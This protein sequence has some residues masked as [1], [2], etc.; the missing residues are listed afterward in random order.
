MKKKTKQSRKKDRWLAVGAL[1]AST[2]F[3]SRMTTPAFAK[4][5]LERTNPSLT[6]DFLTT[7]FDLGSVNVALT[8]ARN[9]DVPDDPQQTTTQRFD[10]PPGPLGDV[11]AA[12]EAATKVKVTV[13]VDV[14]PHPPVARS[15]GAAH[16]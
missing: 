6:R 5:R 14:D 10:I 16:R 7:R 8:A 11:L 2:A 9:W 4:E 12:F 15:V 3:S 1:V 13:T